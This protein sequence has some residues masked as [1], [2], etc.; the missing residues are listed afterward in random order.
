MRNKKQSLDEIHTRTMVWH[1]EK[2]KDLSIKA[3]IEHRDR[4]LLTYLLVPH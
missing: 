1:S 2:E 4:N 3:K